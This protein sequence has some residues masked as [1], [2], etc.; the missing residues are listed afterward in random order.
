[1][2]CKKS[3]PV[4]LPLPRLCQ[5]EWRN[6]QKNLLYALIFITI[7][8]VS[9]CG[10]GTKT[11]SPDPGAGSNTRSKPSI[12]TQPTAQTVT[13]GQ[14]ATFQVVASGSAPLTYQWRN[15]GI[16]IAGATAESYTTPVTTMQSS[17]SSYD[18]VVSN[19]QGSVTSNPAVLTVNAVSSSCPAVP[20]TP[21]A[22]I[23][24]AASTNQINL[25][26][27]GAAANAS[28]TLSYSIYSSTS[29][30]FSPSA[31]TLIASGLTATGYQHTGLQAATTYYYY[32]QAINERGSSPSSTQAFA[33][34]GASSSEGTEIL[35]INSAGSFVSNTSGG[36][37]SFMADE[38]FSGGGVS[39]SNKPVSTAGVSNAAPALVY[40]SERNGDF[41]YTIPG[42]APGAKY[43]VLLHF[44]ETYFTTAGSRVFNVAINGTSVLSKFDIF[45]EA[46]A[47]VAL[48]KQFPAI[49]NSSGQIVVA[50]TRGPADQPKS[51]GLEIRGTPST[52][53]V[54]PATAPSGLSA[55]ASSPSI[56]GLSW[57]GVTAPPNCAVTYN[58]YRN[59]VSGFTPSANNLIASGV[60]GTT[61]LNTGLA[62][63]STY[64]YI[65]QA[66]DSAGTSSP[67][68]AASAQTRPANSCISVPASPASLTGTALSASVIRL[69]WQ[70]IN[71]PANC[72]NITYNLYAD[73][74]D[75]FLPASSNQIASNV[76]G[77]AFYHS[78]LTASTTYYYRVEAADEDGSA[79]SVSSQAS[80]TAMA[81][82]SSL[83]ATAIA[84]N[85]VDLLWPVS[86]LAPQVNYQ[87]Y[88]SVTANF[89][90]AYSNQI[91]TTR[92]NSFQDV[93]ASANTAYYYKVQA[94]N[95]SGSE[96][97]LGPVS[98]ATLPQDQD[99]PFWDGSNIPATPDGAVMMFKIL[100]RTKGKYPDSQVFWD[101]TINGV[102]N[103]HSIAEEAI[104]AMPANASGRMQ[105]YLG[106][107]GKQSSYNDFIEFTIGSTFFNGDT[108]RVDAFG[109]KLAMRLTCSDGTDIAVG[110]NAATFAEDREMTFKRFVK[111]MPPQFQALGQM[112]APYKIVNPGGGGFDAGGQYADY[113]KTYID[114]VWTTNGLTIPKAGAN[115]DGLGDYPDL[116]AAIY[117]HTAGPGTFNPEGKLKS[118][119]M[120]SN[121]SAFYRQAP[122][123]YYAQFWHESAINGVQY[124]FPYDD[125]GGYSSDVSCTGPKTLVIAVGW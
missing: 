62:P 96:T 80:A 42:L 24:T 88:R 64:Y 112:Q 35:A 10:G 101:A 77:G 16:A 28:C 94:T 7:S 87:I 17:G 1:M 15:G 49:A 102:T 46:G 78:N 23:A 93:L 66:G 14:T 65:V 74:T 121:P 71:S 44:A 13:V 89:T 109:V 60:S 32:V 95:N 124:A 103:T 9:G 63:G 61:Y 21:A 26:W 97:P 20:D 98:A 11:T 34:T 120:W 57:T 69:N 122:A 70:E 123:N 5:R 75:G 108:T 19:D 25:S 79:P 105:F 55:V 67:S 106:P 4:S 110:E 81:F 114:E 111:A 27:K 113:Y 91:G 115:G 99:P 6:L 22:L 12:T 59:V 48:V 104:F 8:A 73:T 72:T 54:A 40:Q 83:S 52:C 68:A 43:T 53:T 107:E 30:G 31:A 50:Y 90:P 92:S 37:T 41:T 39:T 116:S 119:A 47:N 100:N 29:A 86:T 82:P 125:A 51:S 2:P 36:A 18:V 38:Y 84:P 58:I 118:Q 56:I 3:F 117:R 85:E 33:T 45:A 76:K